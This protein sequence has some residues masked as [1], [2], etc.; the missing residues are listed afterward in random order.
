MGA[1]ADIVDAFMAAVERK[2]ITAA[3]AFLAD[4]VS[5]ENMPMQPIVG[6]ANVDKALHGFLDSA[7]EVEWKIIRQIEQGDVVA[8]ERIDRF[9]IDGSWIAL[10][11][12]GFFVVANGRITVWRDYFDLPSYTNQLA[13]LRKG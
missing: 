4:D 1:A 2:D 3:V 13:A 12:A 9:C 8:N 7:S 11:V 10:P 5:Y 6:A